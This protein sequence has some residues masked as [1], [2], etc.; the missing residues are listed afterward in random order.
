M[1]WP[2]QS[3]ANVFD[4]APLADN[5]LG[6]IESNQT[7]ALA[8]ANGGSGLA[9]FAKFYTN[10]S[11]RMQTTFPSLLILGQRIESDLEEAM[12]ADWQ[13]VLEGAI[14]GPNTDQIVADAKRYGQALESMLANIPS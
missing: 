4:V 7:D 10:A 2:P 3:K 13:L 5:L 14:S 9:D 11:G 12:Q 6:Y 1:A 8:W